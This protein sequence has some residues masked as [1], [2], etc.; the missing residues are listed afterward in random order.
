MLVT[1]ADVRDIEKRSHGVRAVASVRAPAGGAWVPLL[2]VS[3]SVS[4]NDVNVLPGRTLSMRVM[5]WNDERSNFS[6]LLTIL[7]SWIHVSLE[8]TRLDS[9]TFLVPLGY[10]RT[11]RLSVQPYLGVVDVEASDA[12]DCVQDYELVTLAQG[13]IAEGGNLVNYAAG[14]LTDAM[15]GIP[16]WWA[17]LIDNP[18]DG[19]T[20]A[21]RL[22][23]DG[24]RAS[25]VL[26]LLGPTGLVLTMPTD[27]S[28]VFRFFRLPTIATP[29][30]TT[31]RPGDTGNLETINVSLDRSNIANVAYISYTVDS[32]TY[33][34]VVEY[35]ADPAIAA[36]G[37]F[38]RASLSVSG[39][40][41]TNATQA[42]DAARAAL[43]N[44]VTLIRTYELEVAPIYGVEAGDQLSVEVRPGVL[45]PARVVG[46]RIP[47]TADSGWSLTLA[48]YTAGP[49]VNPVWPT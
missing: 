23:K 4:F 41:I 21:A 31:I 14:M 42:Q 32:V 33:R 30:I 49:D 6:P 19:A 13:E 47:L 39:T 1:V 10:F 40:D 7:G 8:I 28:A 36:G 48:P 24:N 34:E 20:A 5:T 22:Q 37:P 25:A 29:P 26:E 18:G 17:T 27:G 15:A 43:A 9:S 3:G 16:P 44:T 35:T 11:H 46:G 12:G 45:V 2:V 38:G